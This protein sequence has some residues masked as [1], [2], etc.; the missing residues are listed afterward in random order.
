MDISSQFKAFL[1][2]GGMQHDANGFAQYMLMHHRATA[3]A[4]LA[5]H[6]MSHV[7]THTQQQEGVRYD[8]V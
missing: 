5:E 6:I 3:E 4:I 2:S 7:Q 1:G 8:E